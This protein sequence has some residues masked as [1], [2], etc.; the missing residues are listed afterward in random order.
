MKKIDFLER[1]YQ[2]YNQLDDKIIKLEK[3]L[4]TKPLDRREKELLIAQYEYM[5]GYREILNQRI[6]YTKEKYSN[7]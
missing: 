3:A 6:N 5:K 1:M 4:K 7:L 2:E